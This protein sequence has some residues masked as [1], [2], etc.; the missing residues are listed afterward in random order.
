MTRELSVIS[1]QL[2]A[3]APRLAGSDKPSPSEGEGWERVRRRGRAFALRVAPMVGRGL[4][5]PAPPALWPLGPVK[6]VN[7]PE[8][9][10]SLSVAER[11]ARQRGRGL[12]FISGLAPATQPSGV[13]S[14]RAKFTREGR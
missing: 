13:G 8:S 4:T 9:T 10:Q 3:S 7:N 11:D 1:H 14:S 12:P 6:V 2:S 5:P